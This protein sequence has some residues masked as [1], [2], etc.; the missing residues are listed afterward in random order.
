MKY[1]SIDNAKQFITDQINWC[2]ANRYPNFTI[3]S[4]GKDLQACTDT[5]TGKKPFTEALRN[6]EL[7]NKGYWKAIIYR[8]GHR[9]EI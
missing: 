6:G 3:W 7:K 2:K 4:N 9:V 8:D 1:N 5:I